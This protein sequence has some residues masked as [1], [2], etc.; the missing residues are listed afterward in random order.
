M[1]VWIGSVVALLH[2]S[3]ERHNL[4]HRARRPR[5]AQPPRLLA[6]DSFLSLF[7]AAIAPSLRRR[8][9]PLNARRAN[10]THIHVL[11]GSGSLGLLFAAGLARAGHAPV[12]LLRDEALAAFRAR[13]GADGMGTINV[14]QASGGAL[15]AQVRA[16]PAAAGGGGGGAIQHLIVATKA[17]AVAP[18]LRALAPRLHSGTVALLLCNGVLA[19]RDELQRA[20]AGAGDG[21]EP[22]LPKLGRLLVSS[23]S[24]GAFRPSVAAAAGAS[25][26]GAEEA[27]P[28]FAVVHAGVG[29]VVMGDLDHDDDDEEA[30]KSPELARALEA[31]GPLLAARWEPRRALARRAVAAKLVSNCAANAPAGL[32]RCRNGAM[33]PRDDNPA[34]GELQEAVVRECVAAL[35][36][37]EEEQEEQ[38]EQRGEAAVRR[39][40]AAVTALLS[41]T[42]ANVNSLLQDVLAGRRTEVEYL[43]GWV[44]REARR[45]GREAPVNETLARLV[46]M[47]ERVAAD[48]KVV[49]GGGGGG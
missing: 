10:M 29:E 1:G 11:G 39:L 48:D 12:L 7:K 38:E 23:V 14:L 16:E 32:L 24:H 13:A 15:T 36:L 44:A 5:G 30:A 6:V 45:R 35:G 43:N 17:P 49:V 37:A 20:W 18:A 4:Y 46:R 19:V 3:S 31:A 47:A 22:P 2:T 25:A 9:N 33:L 41:G 42:R 21:I 26:A 40:R 34:A 27:P 28:P 8:R